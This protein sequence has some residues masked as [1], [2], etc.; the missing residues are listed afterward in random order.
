MPGI[1]VQRIPKKINKVKR[2][3]YD[4]ERSQQQSQSGKKSEST[5]SQDQNRSTDK[6]MGSKDSDQGVDYSNTIEENELPQEVTSSLDELYPAHEI[7]EIHR[8]DNDSYK[9]KVKNE[10]DVAV[11]YYDSEGSFLRANNLR[12]LQQEGVLPQEQSQK[13]QESQN[14]WETDSRSN[15]QKSQKG[16]GTY[17]QDDHR[18]TGQGTMG[19]GTGDRDNQSSSA[20]ENN[21]KG[22]TGTYDTERSQQQSQRGTI[23][24]ESSAYPQEQNRKVKEKDEASMK[25]ERKTDAEW[26]TGDNRTGNQPGSTRNKYGT[27]T[28]ADTTGQ[29]R[30]QDRVSPQEQSQVIGKDKD[31]SEEVKENDLPELITNSLNELYPDYDIK[32][33]YRANDGSYKVKIENSDDEIAV[34]YDSSGYFLTDE[35]KSEMKDANKDW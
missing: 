6:Q 7:E 5:Y 13:T 22:T 30:G 35:K 17:K 27:T 9:V 33:A 23:N 10:D 34:Y 26:R 21:Q 29:V 15:Q 14:Q 4:T 28:K 1:T 3:T 25:G 19:T 31:Y 24:N 12:G 18:E 8:G 2:G 20:V 32:E 16:T 11:V